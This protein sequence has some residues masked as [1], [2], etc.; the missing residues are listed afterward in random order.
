VGGALKQHL[1]RDAPA[2]S[3]SARRENVVTNDA[4]IEFVSALRIPLAGEAITWSSDLDVFQALYYS[5]KQVD[6]DIRLKE[7]LALGVTFGML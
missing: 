2:E 3:D 4:G 7:T 5:D 6:A 1:D